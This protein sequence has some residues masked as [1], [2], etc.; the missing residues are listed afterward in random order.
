MILGFTGTQSGMSDFQKEEFRK[1]L[2]HY[3]VTELLHG[4]CIGSDEE[5]NN[6]GVQE[7]IKVFTIHPP[8]NPSK[9]SFCFD[10]EGLT[11]FNHILTE[12]KDID[13]M[14]V[15]WQPVKPYLERNI[16]IVEACEVLIATPKEYVHTLRSGTWQ[17]IRHCWKIKK[18][19]VI[20]PP[21]TRPTEEEEV[22]FQPKSE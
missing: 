13:G 19:V 11:K 2:F 20:I 1:L 5:A 8:T 18:H 14:H 10:Y 6:I 4:D 7:G 3:K 16:N 21:V 15:R 12:F 9:R 17:T 22:T